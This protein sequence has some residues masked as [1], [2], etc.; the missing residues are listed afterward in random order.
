M[1]LASRVRG[2]L[3]TVDCREVE[4]LIAVISGGILH[5]FYI[6]NGEFVDFAIRGEVLLHI[7]GYLLLDGLEL[8]GLLQFLLG[9]VKPYK[10]LVAVAETDKI[11]SLL[12]I[13][14]ILFYS[15][16]LQ[17]YNNTVM[18]RGPCA[19][20]MCTASMSAVADGPVKKEPYC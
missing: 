12:C 17:L 19:P 1:F 16:C 13:H 20:V 2:L 15:Y 8:R 4:S 10:I 18:E 9:A 6:R 3:E 5:F 14:N 7:G 11:G